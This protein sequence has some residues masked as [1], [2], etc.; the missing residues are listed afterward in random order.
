MHY[1]LLYD[2]DT[3]DLLASIRP[4]IFQLWPGDHPRIAHIAAP[5][6]RQ[7]HTI[8]KYLAICYWRV[9]TLKA[10]AW[11]LI[12]IQF[13][14]ATLPLV[15]YHDASTLVVLSI[16]TI[17]AFS[18]GCLPRWRE[19]KWCCR[20]QAKGTF[21]VLTGNGGQHVLVVRGNGIGLNFE[22][23]AGGRVLKSDSLVLLTFVQVI[24]WVALLIVIAREDTQSWYL[25]LVGGIGILQNIIVA[26]WPQ[27]PSAFGIHLRAR[28]VIHH[29]KIR[30][31]LCEAEEEIDGLGMVLWPIFLHGREREDNREA[32]EAARARRVAR[33]QRIASE[34]TVEGEN[35][36]VE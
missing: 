8:W 12:A 16:G 6:A 21:C 9:G 29:P 11:S 1:N 19:E 30:D 10:L 25:M 14:F 32:L 17:L 28:R 18:C 4:G 7:M 26:G 3:D 22:D 15:M 33:V 34:T 5:G 13:A 24:L 36:E 35:K 2:Y 31:T 20:R 27:P 23:L